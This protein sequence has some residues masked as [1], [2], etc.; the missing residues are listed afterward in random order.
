MR[1]QKTSGL[2]FLFATAILLAASL[3]DSTAQELRTAAGKPAEG[4]LK[5][6]L[7]KP[8]FDQQVVFSDEGGRVREPYLAIAVDGTL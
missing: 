2:P 1:T 7:G 8:V 6:F 5:P 3:V 4:S